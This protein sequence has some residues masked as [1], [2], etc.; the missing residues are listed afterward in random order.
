MSKQLLAFVGDI[1]EDL[2]LWY[3]KLRLE[4]AG[5]TTRVAGEEVRT[6]AGKHGYPAPADLLIADA[7]SADYAGLLVPGGFMPDKLR[8]NRDV[9]RLTRE[10]FEAGKLVA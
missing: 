1:Y 8:R 10:F 2:E 7:R 9:L 3:P 5:Y 6:F 4:E